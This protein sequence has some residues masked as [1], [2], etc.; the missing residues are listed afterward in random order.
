MTTFHV[1]LV[2]R[3]DLAGEIYRQIRQA[4]LDGGLKAGDRLPS[5]RELARSLAV[6]RSTVTTAYERLLGEG[7]AE[8]RAG[9]ATYVSG[10][11]VRAKRMKPR[12]RAVSALQ[13]RAVWDS[14]SALAAF[15]SR[16]K[17]DFRMGLP[18]AALFPHLVWRRAVARAASE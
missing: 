14:V 4:I 5:T 2:G 7:L 10:K 15:D 13:P 6:S 18:D 12:S 3:G 1:S 16:A 17:F 8:S 11:V 9:T